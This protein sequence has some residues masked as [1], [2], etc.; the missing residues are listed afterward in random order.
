MLDLSPPP[1][2]EEVFCAMDDESVIGRFLVWRCEIMYS[3]HR[4]S[5]LMR[6][7]VDMIAGRM[8]S[9]HQRQNILLKKER[10]LILVAY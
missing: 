1:V 10:S 9:D 6:P 4:N 8:A 3:G 2:V 5:S 7:Q